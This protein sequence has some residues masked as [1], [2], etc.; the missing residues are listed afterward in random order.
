LGITPITLCGTPPNSIEFWSTFGSP[1]NRRI[2]NEYDNKTTALAQSQP[3]NP[4][5]LVAA[6]HIE[7]GLVENGNRFEEV[8][9]AFP[10]L[11][12]GI[13][14]TPSIVVVALKNRRRHN[15]AFRI[16][17]WQWLEQ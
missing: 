16:T 12:V 4:F 14:D 5:G 8:C 15:K 11:Y 2:Q 1:P 17:I 13:R 3:A 9:L 7:E 6:G 10:V